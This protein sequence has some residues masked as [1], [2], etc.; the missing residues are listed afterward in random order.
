VDLDGGWKLFFSGVDLSVS[1]QR[2]CG[3]IREPP[4]VKLCVR[5]DFSGITGMHFELKVECRSI[6]LSQVHV[7]NAVAEYQA[8]VDKVNDALL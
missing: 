6:C 7:P 3:N 5:L 8:C 2:R 1:V 4:F